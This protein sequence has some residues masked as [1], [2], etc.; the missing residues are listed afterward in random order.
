MGFLPISRVVASFHIKT[1]TL[2]R[3]FI[4]KLFAAE[5]YT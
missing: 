4:G 3:A 1:I 5:A 2:E